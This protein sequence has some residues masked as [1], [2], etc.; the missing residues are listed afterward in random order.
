VRRCAKTRCEQPPVATAS[1]LYGIRE[2]CLVDLIRDPDPRF[3]DLCAAHVAN[4]V[5]PLGWVVR[6]DRTGPA[7]D[8]SD[9]VRGTAAI[10]R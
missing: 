10:H 3:V 9:A 1:L 8:A 2:I 6:D 7:A 5:P 4:L